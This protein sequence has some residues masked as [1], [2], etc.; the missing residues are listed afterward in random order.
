[1][2]YYDLYDVNDW[3]FHLLNYDLNVKNEEDLDDPLK[4]NKISINKKKIQSNN[5]YQL[6]ILYEYIDQLVHVG[7]LLTMLHLLIAINDHEVI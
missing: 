2:L 4:T 5:L 3:L 6:M 1:M 7:L